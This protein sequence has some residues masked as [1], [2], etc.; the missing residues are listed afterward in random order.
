M[1]AQ[2]PRRVSLHQ[3][4]SH[5]AS[6]VLTVSGYW[7]NLGVG[8]RSAITD[9]L[10]PDAPDEVAAGDVVRKAQVVP[11]QRDRCGAPR[12]RSMT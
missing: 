8:A 11:R 1:D 12:V 2:I 7:S 4:V 9:G 6:E 5:A 3:L 10:L